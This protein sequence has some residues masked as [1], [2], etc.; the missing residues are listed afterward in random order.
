[1]ASS[2]YFLIQNQ[3]H[4][5]EFINRII[6]GRPCCNVI[7]RKLLLKFP[8]TYMRWIAFYTAVIVE[9]ASFCGI[10]GTI[11]YS[12][13]TCQT[14]M[15]AQTESLSLVKSVV[16]GVIASSI[17]NTWQQ[18]GVCGNMKNAV[19]K[20]NCRIIKDVKTLNQF[21]VLIRICPSSNK[22]C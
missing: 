7:N 11:L 5:F 9:N 18:P 3:I 15:Q 14:W 16:G 8:M 4:D 19:H 6:C 20:N 1:M 10:L 2:F 17:S 12:A 21:L 22:P 13:W